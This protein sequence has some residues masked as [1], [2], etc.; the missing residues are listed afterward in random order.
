MTLSISS[1]RL[2]FL[3]LIACLILA[4]SGSNSGSSAAL[5]NIDCEIIIVGGG[6]AGLYMAY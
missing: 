6:P 3:S 1:I 2:L 4:C 5:T